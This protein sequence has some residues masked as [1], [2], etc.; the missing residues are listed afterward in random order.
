MRCGCKLGIEMGLQRVLR[1][2]TG[3]PSRGLSFDEVQ[4]ALVRAVGFA[5]RMEYVQDV[6]EAWAGVQMK[7][8]TRILSC[9]QARAIEWWLGVSAGEQ[10]FR[11]DSARSSGGTSIRDGVWVWQDGNRSLW[12]LMPL[13]AGFER[14]LP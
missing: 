4:D 8:L 13:S 11:R 10:G 12:W 6:T 5:V 7:M 3:L 14:R 1:A 2:V 9:I